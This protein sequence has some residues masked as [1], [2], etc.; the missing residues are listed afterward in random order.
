MYKPYD[1]TILLLDIY[2]QQKNVN[3]CASKDPNKSVLSSTI[4]DS[5]K[6]ETTQVS[7]N[8]RMNE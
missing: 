2:S 8:S 6:L 5:P 7:I 1:Q 4:Y 3:R